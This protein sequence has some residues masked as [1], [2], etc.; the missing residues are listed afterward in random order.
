MQELQI[1]VDRLKQCGEQSLHNIS[2]I[3]NNPACVLELESKV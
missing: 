2:S 1:E 3:S